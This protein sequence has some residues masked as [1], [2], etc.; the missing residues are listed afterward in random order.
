[1]Y[2]AFCVERATHDCF[3][4]LQLI[5]APETLSKCLD[6][7]LRLS[8]SPAQSASQKSIQSIVVQD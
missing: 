7:D 5:G 3:L 8:M 1:M 6:V 2:S 4:L